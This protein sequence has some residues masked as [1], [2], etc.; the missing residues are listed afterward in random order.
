VGKSSTGHLEAQEAMKKLVAC[1]LVGLTNTSFSDDV[2]YWVIY[3]SS[4]LAS[5]PEG[6]VSLES[7]TLK[8]GGNDIHPTIFKNSRQHG[9]RPG[10][11]ARKI[12]KVEKNLERTRDAFSLTLKV[13]LTPLD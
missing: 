8:H 13:K 11:G 4:R 9:Y 1:R 6:Y 7:T 10:P 5:E 2:G 12:T 3:T